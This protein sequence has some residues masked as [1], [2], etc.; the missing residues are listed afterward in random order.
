MTRVQKR[1]ILNTFDRC[2]RSCFLGGYNLQTKRIG[3]R[4]SNIVS[5]CCRGNVD[6]NY[7]KAGIMCEP[8]PPMKKQKCRLLRQM[9]SQKNLPILPRNQ[10]VTFLVENHY[11]GD[12]DTAW[13]GFPPLSNCNTGASTVAVRRFDCLFS[14]CMTMAD[15]VLDGSAQSQ[16][17]VVSLS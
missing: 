14:L 10:Y 4:S 7:C 12:H 16:N 3:H 2:F 9:A 8:V 17:L 1:A 13:S 6:P 11:H 5:V 15:D